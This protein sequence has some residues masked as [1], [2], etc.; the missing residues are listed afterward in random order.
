MTD[1]MTTTNSRRRR[2]PAPA[3]PVPSPVRLIRDIYA[4]KL[5][6]GRPVV[7]VE[8][9]PPKTPKGDEALF[10]WTLPALQTVAP[11]FYSVTYGAGGST[12]DKT[13]SVVDRIQRE[14]RATA[15]AHLTCISTSRTDIEH[16][17]SE[18][19]D[20]GIRNIL[21]LRGDPPQDGG[22]LARLESGF[23][24]SYQLVAFIKRTGGFSIGTAGFPESHIACRE[25]K[26]VD[27]QRLKAKID[28]GA[29]FVLTQLFFNNDDYFTF[30]DYLAGTLGVTVPIIPGVLPILSTEQIKRFTTICGAT[31]PAALLVKLEAFGDDAKAVADF[32]VELATRQCEALLAGG[33]PGVHIYSLNKPYATTRIISD[34][35]LRVPRDAAPGA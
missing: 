1:R 8:F 19:R 4:D 33:A 3:G 35:G 14:H 2:R 30:R 16:Y 9:F 10:G 11:D 29:D 20:R 28:H 18:A 34:L 26:H 21:A 5:A 12:R 23:D 15:M 7:S 25:G 13:L 27:W 32:G 6:S 31:L 22:E 17:L 24:Y